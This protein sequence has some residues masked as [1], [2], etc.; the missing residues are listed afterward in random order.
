MTGLANFK[1]AV[2]SAFTAAT[3]P[4]DGSALAYRFIDSFV[5]E[6]GDGQHRELLW[7]RPRRVRVSDIGRPN[8]EFAIDCA[9]FLARRDRT[10]DIFADA[11]EEEVRVLID[12]FDNTTALG[13]GVYEGVMDDVEIEEVTATRR[14]RSG[15]VPR[16]VFARVRFPF[17]V[18]VGG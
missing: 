7:S 11:I 6:R 13:A 14:T 15:G 10:E 1:V 9:L 8:R 3:P 18:L 16:S 2:E 4:V 17:R 5:E 12:R